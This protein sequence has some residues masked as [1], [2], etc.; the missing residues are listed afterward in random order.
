MIKL[1]LIR[2]SIKFDRFLTIHFGVSPLLVL[3]SAT[4]FLSAFL[5]LGVQLMVAKMILPI[6]GGSPSVWNTCMFFFQATLLLG[7]GYAHLA[8]RWWGVRRHAIFHSILLF[9]PLAFYRSHFR[10]LK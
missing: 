4:L 5:L 9:I 10:K 3:F 6:L 8:T 7:Y 2:K 1:S